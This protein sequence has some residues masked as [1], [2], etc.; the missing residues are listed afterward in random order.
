MMVT[1]CLLH[2]LGQPI[3]DVVFMLSGFAVLVSWVSVCLGLVV[4]VLA[5][6]VDQAAGI[7]GPLLS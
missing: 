3:G 2:D 5:R 1:A 4:S 7:V 6:S